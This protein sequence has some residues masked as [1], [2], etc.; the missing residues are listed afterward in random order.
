MATLLP[1]DGKLPELGLD[2]FVAPNAVLIG[3]VV[4][5]EAASVWF[6]CVLRA[7][8][9]RIRIGARTNVQD[10]A[11]AHMTGG[12][13]H[14]QV[15]ADVTIG[16]GAILHGATIEDECL[17]GM[18]AIV[19]DN[20]VVGRGSVV[21][22]GA[23]VPPRMVIPPGSLVLGNPGKVIRPVSEA[24][25]ALGKAGADHYVDSARTYRALLASRG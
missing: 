1:F 13:S 4:L 12:V 21:G 9:G 5:G 2:A 6:G 10:L 3:D 16:H 14:L 11:C 8:V 25:R 23:L 20:A 18:G 17:V 7:D 22:A 19:L 24:E 15:G